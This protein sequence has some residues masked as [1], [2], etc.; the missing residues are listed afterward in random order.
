[1]SNKRHH[2]GKSLFNSTYI[3]CQYP[4]PMM[5]FIFPKKHAFE[6]AAE[7]HVRL[8]RFLGPEWTFTTKVSKQ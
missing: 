7:Y 8:R 4:M 6:R 1:M 2:Y 3:A 5:L